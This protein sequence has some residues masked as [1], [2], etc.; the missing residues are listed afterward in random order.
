MA[1]ERQ[2]ALSIPEEHELVGWIKR[3]VSL[4]NPITL[5]LTK[6]LAFEIRRSRT[7]P[8]TPDV[9]TE[10]IGTNWLRRFRSRHPEIATIS[11]RSLEASRFE[12]TSYDR[13]NSFFD[14]LSSLY[15]TRPYDSDSIW[16]FDE[17]GYALGTSQSIKVLV[18]IEDKMN[19]KK[20][21]GRQ[22]WITTIEC[23]GASGKLGLYLP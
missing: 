7:P 14:Q 6:E 1:H 16:N 15:G 17:T 19:F 23:V 22:E 10:P 21:P 9:P 18:T 8:T 13:I 11:S 3:L 20:V 5:P 4:G 12:G 2:Q